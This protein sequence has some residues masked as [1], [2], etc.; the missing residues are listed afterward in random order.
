MSVFTKSSRPVILTLLGRVQKLIASPIHSFPD[1]SVIAIAKDGTHRRK[2]ISTQDI[3]AKSDRKLPL[4]DLRILSKVENRNFCSILPRPQSNCIIMEIET[5]RL[6]CWSDECI[7][8]DKDTKIHKQFLDQLLASLAS[9]GVKRRAELNPVLRLYINSDTETNGVEFE[10][11]VLESALAVTL[12]K[13]ERHIELMMPA[14]DLLLQ[15]ITSDPHSSMLRRLLAVKKS[16]SDFE[17]NVNNVGRIVQGLLSNDADLIG[18]YLTEKNREVSQHEEMELLLES[19]LADIEDIQSQIKIV[20]ETIDDTNHFIAAHLDATRNRMIRMSLFMEMG[21]LSLGSGALIAGV[22]GMNL[23]HGLE[24]HPTAFYVTCA[25]V[26]ML[27]L[28]LFTKF[29]FNYNKLRS[30]TTS[31]HSYKVVRNFLTYVDDMEDIINTSQTEITED[32]FRQ[33]LNK[34]VGQ[35]VPAE[36]FEFI[37]QMFDQNK[38]RRINTNTEFKL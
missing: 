23:T 29:R 8:I 6:I 37:F 17:A 33:A 4:R 11:K 31:A 10:Q 28:T 30:D 14:V 9:N 34:L 22:F 3:L 24:S 25:G 5:L 12:N 35:Q 32:Q 16:L 27:M 36:E 18:L 1:L 20:K 19:Y 15:Q 38:D 26:G 21:T 7:V 2:R 13:Y